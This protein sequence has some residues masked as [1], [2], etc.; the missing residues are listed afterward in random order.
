MI[1]ALDEDLDKN[2]WADYAEIE[3]GK[4]RKRVCAKSRKARQRTGAQQL[5]ITREESHRNV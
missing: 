1:F 3:F 4:V 5:Q 2:L